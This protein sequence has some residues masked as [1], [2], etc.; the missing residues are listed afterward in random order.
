MN[1]LTNKQINN[2]IKLRST[3][4][5]I[6]SISNFDFSDILLN[7]LLNDLNLQSY[8]ELSKIFDQISHIPLTTS[9]I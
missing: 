7:E 8:N 6:T 2:L 4:L 9:K 3:Y 1:K 5:H